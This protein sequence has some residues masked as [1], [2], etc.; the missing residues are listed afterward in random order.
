[1][2]MRIYICTYNC[3]RVIPSRSDEKANVLD[4]SS[5]TKRRQNDALGKWEVTEKDL[6]SRVRWGTR[7]RKETRLLCQV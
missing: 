3:K 5:R 2:R 6:G 4:G 7:K 1:M